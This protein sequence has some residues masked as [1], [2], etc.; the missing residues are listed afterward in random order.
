MK[1]KEYLFKSIVNKHANI[2]LLYKLL[3][4]HTQTNILRECPTYES[5]MVNY[6]LLNLFLFIIIIIMHNIKVTL[7]MFFFVSYP[8]NMMY[9]ITVGKSCLV[10]HANGM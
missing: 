1:I 5:A 8:H 2:Y 3:F 4:A 7:T 9:A 6:I 10:I